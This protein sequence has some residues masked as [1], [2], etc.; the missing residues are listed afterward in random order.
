[1]TRALAARLSGRHFLTIGVGAIMGVGWAVALGDW[2]QAAAPLGAMLGFLLG[3]VLMLPVALCYAELATAL[4]AA[5][6]EVVYI[7]A[8]FGRESAFLVGWFLVL[9]ATAITSF[10][11]ISL[12]WFLGQLFPALEGP[13]AYSV[14]GKD[15]HSGALVVGVVFTLLITL[16]N[17]LGAHVAGRFQELFTYIKAVA[18]IGFLGAAVA[19]GDVSH[20][21]PVLTPVAAQPAIYGV[22]WIA[23]TAALWYAG[24]QVVPQAIEERSPR[25]SVRTVAMMTVLALVLGVVFYCAVVLACTLAVPWRTLVAAPLPAAMAV[26]AVVR[27]DLIARLVL[28]AIVLGILATWNSAFLW[29]SRLLLALGRQGSVPGVFARVGRWH[30]PVAAVL[31]VGVCG[32]AGIGLGRGA[33]VPIINMASIS[34]T[35]SYAFACWAVLRLRE[36]RPTLARPFRVPGGRTTM[37]IAIAMTG[38]M[39]LISLIEPLLRDR[40]VPL[41]W[42]LLIAWTAL[43]S[44][45]LLFARL[46]ERPRR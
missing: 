36:T 18:V 32:L 12:A 44:L 10:E 13:V 15:L 5:G 45:F 25:T 35:F 30:S 2:L 8:V 9:M 27:S 38:V 33:L 41:E 20:L 21:S 42:L 39:G 6:A 24:F 26:H 23:S 4:P 40:R 1:M 22:L 7:E 11:G 28:G 29:A 14:L 34:L 46:G 43:G 31:L 17:V 3:G 19:L 16:V 37:R